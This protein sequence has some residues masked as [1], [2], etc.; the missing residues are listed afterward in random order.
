M[1]SKKFLRFCRENL[2]LVIGVIIL[3]IIVA[4]VFLL[5]LFNDT[6]PNL[7]RYD[8]ILKP[9]SAENLLGTDNFGRDLL[10]RII[11]G[12]RVSLTIGLQVTIGTT[13]LGVAIALLA[14]YY[15]KFD[16]IV[17]RFMDILMAFP[18]LLMAI[19]L[20]A[21]FSNSTNGVSVA[22][23][24]A[25]TPRTVRIVRSAI[26][27]IREEVYIEAARSIGVKPLKIMLRHILPGTIPVLIVQET[28]LFAYAILAEAGI[29][30]VGVGVQPPDASWGNIL[31]DSTSLLREAPWMVLYPG[32][33]ILLTVLSLNLIGDG[34]REI[35][36]PKRKKGKA[37][38]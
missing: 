34:L 16:I 19:A 22:L 2:S 12:G 28:F 13:L 27:T 9:P 33:V 18:S 20:T 7:I 25:Y 35:L 32:I 21:I 36:D 23:T 26:L 17:M 6:D 31:S 5:P 30:F 1:K 38:D 4:A 24:V 15:E 8:Q 14:G 3:T 10:A 37:R 11:S 29:S